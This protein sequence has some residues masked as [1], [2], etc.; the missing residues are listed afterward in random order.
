VPVLDLLDGSATGNRGGQPQHSIEARAGIGKNGLGARLSL[1]WQS[2]T[3]V[4]TDPSGATISPDDLF[5]SELAT[6]DLRLFA[7]LGQRRD[8]V[9]RLPL[10]RGTRIS[11]A[12][13]NI[14]NSR[15]DVRDRNG[16][17]PIGYQRDLIDPLGR[18]IRVSLRKLFF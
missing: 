4:L 7:D 3:R 2:G 5:F 10:L 6:I 13:D 16:V 8:L 17:V 12:I 18:T 11:L 9:R 15:L 1:N 14:T